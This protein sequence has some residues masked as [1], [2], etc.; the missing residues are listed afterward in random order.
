MRAYRWL[1]AP[2]AGATLGSVAAAPPERATLGPPVAHQTVRAISPES[3]SPGANLT[4]PQPAAP[5]GPFAGQA[6]LT[7]EA[8]VQQVLA[9][10]PSLVQMTA[11]FEAA[12]ARYPQVRSLDDP[13][14][15]STLAPNALRTLA[16]G[17]SGYRLEVSQKLPW[18]GK[19]RARGD[20]VLAEASAAAAD[21]EDMR[22]QLVESARSAFFD[23]YLVERA[24]DV[25]GESLRLLR[26]FKDN[27]ESRYKNGLVPQQDILQANV[28]IGQQRERQLMLERM[29]E[30]AVAR[31]NTL[32]HLPPDLPLPPPPKEVGPLALPAETPALRA[33]AV[34]HRPDLKALADRIAADQASVAVARK[35]FGPDVELLGAYD[36]FWSNQQ[37]RAQVGIRFNLPVRLAKRYAAVAEAQARLAQRQA[38]LARQ[39]DQVNYQVQEA[40]AQVRE[41][42]RAVQLYEGEILRAAQQ[43]VQAAQSAYVAGKIAFLALIEAQRSVITLRD[44]YYE[45]VAAYGRRVATLERVVGGPI[46]L[47]SP[48]PAAAPAR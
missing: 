17:S 13:M 31:I 32:M 46:G 26:E 7:A 36:A 10:N 39:T 33:A 18:F 2:L 3:P 48:G 9:R 14:F 40:A 24:L 19:L 34:A 28:E 45:A 47:P 22:L 23:Y 5:A 12:Q 30:V 42:A 38:E 15:G 1:L 6:A 16:D 21:I 25:N 35:E 37:Q 11:A 29:R 4:L 41:S 8:L 43:N 20:N 44:R 27:A